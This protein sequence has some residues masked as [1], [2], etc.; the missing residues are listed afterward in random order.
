MNEELIIPACAFAAVTL[1]GYFVTSL[2]GGRDDG[3]IRDRLRDRDGESLDGPNGAAA[4]AAARTGL[5]PFLERMGQ[6]AAEPFMPKSREKQSGL[7]QQLG[8]AGIYS[9]QAIR[10]VTGCKVILLCVGLVGGYAVGSVLDMVA[11][12][13]SFGG[14]IGYMAPVVWL[15]AAVS[16]NQKALTHGLPDALDLMVV[17]VEAGLTVDAG[18]QRVGSELAIAHPAISRE[19]GIAHME[20]RVGLSRSESMRNLGVR[21]GTPGLQA[22]ASMLIQ[23]DRFG[24]SI[25]QALRIHS[26]TLRLNRQHAAE[27]MAAKASVKM[28]FPLVLFIFPATFIVLAGPTIIELMKSP[29]MTE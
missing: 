8:R 17:C 25:A 15:K 3:K 23:A 21:T 20:T 10:M 28:S 16:A 22:L 9:P 18:M 12:G 24:T 11:L 29:I 6:A 7:R 19:F 4:A 14:L 2:L 1:L 26:E 13:L 5:R 27:E